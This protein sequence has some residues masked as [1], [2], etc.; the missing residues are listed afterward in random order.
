MQKKVSRRRA[1]PMVVKTNTYRLR[2]SQQ[3]FNENI[4]ETTARAMPLST[5]GKMHLL[6][7]LIQTTENMGKRLNVF[8]ALF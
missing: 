6:R 5:T 4:N 1:H 8:M 7:I 3:F 2:A